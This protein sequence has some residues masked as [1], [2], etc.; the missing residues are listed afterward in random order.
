MKKFVAL[1]LAVSMALTLASCG[2]TPTGSTPASKAEGTTTITGDTIK[3]G[4]L[5]PL[6]GEVSVYG[7]ATN[8]GVQ[9]AVKDINAAGGI[10]GKQIECVV[11]DEKGDATEAVN[12]YNK[13]VQDDK[14]VAIVGD[15]TSGATLAVAQQSL[16][17]GIPLITGTATA[18]AVT[19]TGENVFR[20][21]FTD[22]FQ[23]ELMAA[24]ASQKLKA[25]TVA[26]LY[27]A[28]DDYSS[29]VAAAF[30][31]AA[32]ADG[33]TI[34]TQEK[35]QT[36]D[37]D[38]KSQLTTIKGKNPDVLMMPV[39]AEPLRIIAA[40]AKEVGITSQLMGVD[41][42]DG[43]L[44]DANFDAS[45]LEGGLFCSQYSA[46]STDEALQK[47]IKT[48]KETN[49]TDPNM[50]SVLGYDAMQIMAKAI[51]KAGS[52]DAAAII[53][54]LNATD[55]VGLTGNITFDENRNPIKSSVIMSVKGGAYKYV[56]NYE[57]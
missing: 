21:C 12:A 43:V 32:E 18:E 39:Y 25:K 29:G 49:N 6:T 9:Q 47:F 31:K 30:V 19:T 13:L 20:A 7:V 8:N 10:G 52:A 44:S 48:Y 40:Q 50:F 53:D 4:V 27:N 1:T 22:P 35:F 45:V 3:I 2:S 33:I 15:V 34:V 5:A 23:G 57:K 41:G 36:G 38:F 16:Q 26:V 17:D 42:W 24:Y 55:Y 56:E 46:E 28:A 11:Y 51:E 37:V 54:A 14:V